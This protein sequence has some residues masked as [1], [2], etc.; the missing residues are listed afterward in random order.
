MVPSFF[1][2]ETCGKTLGVGRMV[3]SSVRVLNEHLTQGRET[4][5]WKS[6]Y[7]PEVGNGFEWKVSKKDMCLLGTIQLGSH[8]IQQLLFEM[9]NEFWCVT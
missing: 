9:L 7:V 1:D 2:L 6:N 5:S 8:L 4:R 3:L